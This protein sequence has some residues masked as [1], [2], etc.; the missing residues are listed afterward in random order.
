[1]VIQ[2]NL[3]AMNVLRNMQ[4]QSAIVGKCLQRLSSG[5]KINSA[6]DD[7][8]GLGI[9][10]RMRSQIRGLSMAKQNSLNAISMLQTAE[11]GLNEMH[12]IAQRMR[13][14][15]VQASNG[16]YMD[17]DRALI[18]KEYEALK[19]ELDRLSDY[20]N[21]NGI[22]LLD[23]SVGGKKAEKGMG[24]LS[25]NTISVSGKVNGTGVL[26][27]NVGSDGAGYAYLRVDDKTYCAE[28]GAGDAVMRFG[29]EGGNTV[30]ITFNV[31]ELKNGALTN[32]KFNGSLADI[33]GSLGATSN[34]NLIFQIGAN[35]SAADRLEIRI[36]NMSTANLGNADKGDPLYKSNILTREAAIKA[37]D[38]LD[39]TINQISSQRAGIGAQ[40]NRLTH[41]INN[42]ETTAENLQ[43]AES[44]IRDA[45]M[46][47]EMMEYTKHNI[48]LQ[49]AQAMMAQA[50]RQP[51]GVL[52]LL[53]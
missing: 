4:N 36:D 53:R 25:L 27:L 21:Y 16:T 24:N 15:A 32:I 43:A 23:G 48:L 45:D 20:T 37:T 14:L 18:S 17:E 12:A 52:Q 51:E 13:E 29:I 10:E 7:A 35:G 28:I 2:H 50:M 34:G 40:I 19:G 49:A 38:T 6:A 46:A 22:K 30:S 42:L 8:A 1:M 41:T 3:M 26:N 31:G 47:K 11:G 39:K 33:S 44:A 9:S 5:S